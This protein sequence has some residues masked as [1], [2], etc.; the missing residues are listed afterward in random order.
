MLPHPYIMAYK[1]GITTIYLKQEA[2]S[3]CDICT[4]MFIYTDILKGKKLGQTS[5][6]TNMNVT[7]IIK[8]CLNL[9]VLKGYSSNYFVPELKWFCKV[10]QSAS[11][12]SG[13]AKCQMSILLRVFVP[14]TYTNPSSLLQMLPTGY[15]G[16]V[17]R[18]TLDGKFNF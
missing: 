18:R 15:Q 17:I 10:Y 2:L 13:R 7:L 5:Y 3:C 1:S 9:A 6:R 4:S 11:W 8:V 14:S 16:G 12:E